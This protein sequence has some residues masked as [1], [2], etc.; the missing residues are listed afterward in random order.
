MQG[1]TLDGR[2]AAA[3][4]PPVVSAHLQDS[5]SLL[6]QAIETEDHELLDW[7]IENAQPTSVPASHLAPLIY[8]LSARFIVFSD[9]KV[10]DW[11][12][13]LLYAQHR[14]ILT[15]SSLREILQDLKLK[16]QARTASMQNLRRLKGRLDLL[17]FSPSTT[18]AVVVSRDPNLTVEE[19]GESEEM[20]EDYVK[21]S[22]SDM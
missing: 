2:L 6:L 22:V 11:L 15:D 10:M 4:Q 12:Q 7:C 20:D 19:E 1:I 17:A 5:N 9:V 14:D 8:H 16:L 18:N 13:Y 21:F 3:V